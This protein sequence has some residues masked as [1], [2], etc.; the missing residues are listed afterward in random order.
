MCIW[1]KRF[2]EQVAQS[3]GYPLPEGDPAAGDVR[4]L[5]EAD[6]IIK[7]IT[8]TFRYL[9]F[10]QINLTEDFA[11]FLQAQ[12]EKTRS[13]IRAYAWPIFALRA[14]RDLAAYLRS[15]Y[16]TELP[17][18]ESDD[19]TD[20]DRRDAQLAYMRRLEE[21]DPWPDDDYPLEEKPGND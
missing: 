9:P 16:G 7:E 3:L 15:R 1:S 6:G 12:E 13:G 11:R 10:E 19:W 17:A 5:Q 2:A 21:E 14:V 8:E 4:L 20:E 18:D